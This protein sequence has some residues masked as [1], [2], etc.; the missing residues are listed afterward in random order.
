MTK[1]IDFHTHYFPDSIAPKTLEHLK[2][3][4]MEPVTSYGDGTIAAVKEYMKRDGVAVSV[5]APP[6]TK[7]EQVIS[8]NR[9]MIAQ[10]ETG[11]GS[12]I[13]L[14]A[15]HPDF[16]EIGNVDEELAFIAS[17]GIKGIKLH[18]EYQ[19]FYPDDPEH[20]EIYEACRKHNLFILF[21]AGADL[22]FPEIHA[23]PKRLAQ[24]AT[25]EG[26]TLIMAHM[27]GYKMWDDVTKY[28]IGK[29]IYLDT[30]YCV[31]MKDITIK[32]MIMAHGPEKILFGT[33]FPWETAA[34]IEKKLDGIIQGNVKELIY[35]KNAE[36]LL[37][38]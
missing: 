14:G 10:N 36:K 38:L 5:N 31:E 11:D 4:S 25:I 33:D 35:H 6:A 13:C 17:K 30:A 29:N 37:G 7:K 19:A 23:T 1:I 9:K 32:R 34:N 21:H 8:I 26:L 12:V 16:Y 2:S 15:M 24:V 20:W 3:L 22:A 28:L 18:P 27:G